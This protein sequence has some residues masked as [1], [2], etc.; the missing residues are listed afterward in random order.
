MQLQSWISLCSYR[1]PSTSKCNIWSG[2]WPY[3][4]GWLIL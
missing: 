1:S 3:I 4:L 2:N